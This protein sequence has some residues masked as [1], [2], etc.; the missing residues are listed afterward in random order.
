[1]KHMGQVPVN[2]IQR[3]TNGLTSAPP[4]AVGS[5]EMDD[6]VR[7]EYVWCSS[8]IFWTA[9]SECLIT[10]RHKH[11]S[12]MEFNTATVQCDDASPKHSE[13]YI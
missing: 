4:L 10:R 11:W 6:I 7:L 9:R 12:C 8:D 2:E 3:G 5:V 13:V 1:M